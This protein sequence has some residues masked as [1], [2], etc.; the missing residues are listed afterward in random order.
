MTENIVLPTLAEALDFFFW[1]SLKGYAGGLEKTTIECLPRPKVIQLERPLGS[2]GIMQYTDMYYTSPHGQSFGDTV[3]AFNG[4]VVWW[5]HYDGFW[6]RTDGRI[7]PF[8][9]ERLGDAYKL[10]VFRGGRGCDGK[11][12]NA[13]EY[14]NYPKGDFQKF[15]GYD[16]IVTG[17]EPSETEGGVVYRHDYRGGLLVPLGE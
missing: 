1:A 16:M 2:W 13:L 7:I 8:L 5:M 17:V 14:F 15:S 6:K 10:N 3:I 12:R 4:Q 9:K 11:G